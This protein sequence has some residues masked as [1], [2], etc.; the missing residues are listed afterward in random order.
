[1][2]ATSIDFSLEMITGAPL[3]AWGILIYLLYIGIKAMRSHVV[4]IPKLFIIPVVFLIINSKY[5][6]GVNIGGYISFMIMGAFAGLILAS[7]TRIKIFKNAKSIEIPGNYYIMTILLLFFVMK[8]VFGYL[9]AV[10]SATALHYSY[11]EVYI[12]ALLSG[13][14][15]GRSLCYLYRFCKA[16]RCSKFI[17]HY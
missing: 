14:F 17:T 3:W 8:Y 7:K 9:H 10:Q 5:M 11:I 16:R 6:G 4:Y 12:G 15:W 13:F 2:D 1:M